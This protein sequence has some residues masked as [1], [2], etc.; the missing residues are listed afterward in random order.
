[1]IVLPARPG[2]RYFPPILQVHFLSLLLN[3]RDA[4][5]L[6]I[7]VC[8]ASTSQSWFLLL[9]AKNPDTVTDSGVFY[10]LLETSLRTTPFFFF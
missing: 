4:D 9:A 10:T 8:F 5:I 1:M 2:A 6:L 3:L 7:N